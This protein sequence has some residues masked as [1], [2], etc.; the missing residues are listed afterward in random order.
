MKAVQLIVYFSYVSILNMMSC[1]T[2]IGDSLV[3]NFELSMNLACD[4]S[5]NSFNEYSQSL[6]LFIL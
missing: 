1:L 2:I 6:K 5:G 3:Y 4:F